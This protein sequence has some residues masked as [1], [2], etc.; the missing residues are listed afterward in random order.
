MARGRCP[1]RRGRAV[2]TTGPPWTAAGILPCRRRTRG[3]GLRLEPRHR[4]PSHRSAVA[5]CRSE[6]AVPNR[7]DSCR[8]AGSAVTHRVPMPPRTARRSGTRS[9]ACAPGTT[10]RR[11]GPRSSNSACNCAPRQCACA[12]PTPAPV[13]GWRRPRS[14]MRLRDRSIRRAG[15]TRLCRC[16]AG[17]QRSAVLLPAARALRRERRR[18]RG[19]ARRNSWRRSPA[20]K[21]HDRAGTGARRDEQAHPLSR[22][23]RV[24]LAG[25]VAGAAAESATAPSRGPAMR[26]ASVAAGGTAPDSAA[27]SASSHAGN[28]AEFAHGRSYSPPV[29]GGSGSAT[30]MR[31]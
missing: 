3:A 28:S 11:L 29:P 30:S 18:R 10:R 23:R 21:A 15:A 4:H 12:E 17:R 19:R 5:G 31:A 26:R 13:N 27:A 24:P 16:R 22:T 14:G 2:R 1:R 20:P 7:A 9:R 8:G 25:R 6:G